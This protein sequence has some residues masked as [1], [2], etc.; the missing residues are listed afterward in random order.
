MIELHTFSRAWDRLRARFGRPTDPDE[1]ADY[2][3]YLSAQMD[4]PQFLAA[5]QVLW[6]NARWFPRP[7]DF[8]LVGATGDWRLVLLAMD[9]YAPPAWSWV[10]PWNTMTARSREACLA[11]GGIEGMRA[12]REQGRLLAL[13][14][15]W[16]QAYEQVAASEVLQ[17]IAQP[18]PVGRIGSG[19]ARELGAGQGR[20][21]GAIGDTVR[22]MV[23]QARAS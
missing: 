6:A 7:V 5:C 11:L 18:E 16:E 4:E 15:A 1:A 23:P 10:G 17:A 20:G 12:V 22:R 13:K 19:S 9:G 21:M 3:A 8:V 14:A 2:H